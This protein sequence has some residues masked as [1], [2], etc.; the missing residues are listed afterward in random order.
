M[1]KATEKPNPTNVQPN[2]DALTGSEPIT[3]AQAPG[4]HLQAPQPPSTWHYV[5]V[6]K[7]KP[8]SAPKA[9]IGLIGTSIRTFPF[10]ILQAAI[11]SKRERAVNGAPHVVNQDHVGDAVLVQVDQGAEQLPRLLRFILRSTL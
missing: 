10:S 7:C 4:V 9:A 1:L 6:S 2:W 3:L 8:A 5:L 11:I